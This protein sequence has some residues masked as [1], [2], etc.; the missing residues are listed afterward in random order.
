LN[1]EAL[2]AEVL[3]VKGGLEYT[4]GNLRQARQAY[5]AALALFHQQGALSEITVMF[6]DLGNIALS[7]DDPVAARRHLEESLRLSRENGFDRFEPHVLGSLGYL[8]L[9]EENIE[10]ADHVLRKGLRL[11]L[12]CD[13]IGPWTTHDLY[14]LAA[15][16]AI[17]DRATSACVLLGSC[18]GVLDLVGVARE[19]LAESVRARARHEAETKIGKDAADRAQAR[20]SKLTV[21]EAVQYALSLD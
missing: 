9:A 13:D 16:T 21:V 1:D 7:A 5:E 2:L 8:E 6:H 18:D 12:E 17:R 3:A 10:Q 19:P 4:S 15:V 14:A 11:A 20:G